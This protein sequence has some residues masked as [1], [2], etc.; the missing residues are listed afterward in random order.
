MFTDTSDNRV[1][2]VSDCQ[3]ISEETDSNI[4]RRTPSGCSRGSPIEKR[5]GFNVGR[6][7]MWHDA[8]A[9]EAG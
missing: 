5:G 8:A 6:E 7:I 2:I 3:I 1:Y 9:A 4:E